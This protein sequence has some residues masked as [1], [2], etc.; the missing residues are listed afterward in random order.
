MRRASLPGRRYAR[1][2][3][4]APSKRSVRALGRE[5]V[6]FCGEEFFRHKLT[7]DRS[8]PKTRCE[9]LRR[10]ATSLEPSSPGDY[11][12]L[13]SHFDSIHQTT[14]GSESKGAKGNLVQ[15][16]RAGHVEGRRESFF[17]VCKIV[18]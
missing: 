8:G 1:G 5:S 17:T 4:R 9:V 16:W 14:S 3:Y 10:G 7:F 11:E 18:T 12:L 13:R 2:S 6:F 15:E